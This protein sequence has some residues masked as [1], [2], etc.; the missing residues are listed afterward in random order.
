MRGE[1]FPYR[2]LK[3]RLHTHLVYKL[4]IQSFCLLVNGRDSLENSVL[5]MKK[6]ITM[7]ISS[8]FY[9]LLWITYQLFP[10]PAAVSLETRPFSLEELLGSRYLETK[11]GVLVSQAVWNQETLHGSVFDSSDGDVESVLLVIFMI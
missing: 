10:Q 7:W 9:P 4:S 11:L 8:D 5:L 6:W 2:V 3:E 1:H